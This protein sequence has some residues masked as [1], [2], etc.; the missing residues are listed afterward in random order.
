MPMV[1]YE[2]HLS[3]HAKYLL[4][5]D[6]LSQSLRII[7]H[8][9]NMNF[10]KLTPQEL[11]TYNSWWQTSHFSKSVVLQAYKSALTKKKLPPDYRERSEVLESFLRLM[12]SHP[13]VEFVLFFPPYSLAY[14]KLEYIT[15]K[16]GY[17]EDM[18]FRKELMKKLIEIK[19]VKL[20]D[21][22]TDLNTI[23]NLDNY[24][25]FIHYCYIVNEYIV[26]C[27]AKNNRLVSIDNITH[28]QSRFSNLP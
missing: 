14:H 5:L 1:L 24:K 21:F 15:N 25:D 2:C 9:A 27:I 22:E 11:E 17:D 16:P 20:F 6:M 7:L 18:R 12:H 10:L 19:N 4:N 8:N 3:A 28:F 13:E 23:S 26:D